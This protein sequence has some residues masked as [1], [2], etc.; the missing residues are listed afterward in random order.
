MTLRYGL[1]AAAMLGLATGAIANEGYVD[2]NIPSTHGAIHSGAN[3]AEDSDLALRVATALAADRKLAEPGVTVTVSA[4]NGKVMLSGSAD[5]V[6]QAARAERVAASVA[7]RANVTG[8]LS[9][10][11]G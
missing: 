9:V 5:S 7:G 10:T 1:I 6:D 2:R 4:N 3:N 11:A 8:T